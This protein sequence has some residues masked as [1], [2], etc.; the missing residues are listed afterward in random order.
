MLSKPTVAVV[1]IKAIVVVIVLLHSHLFGVKKKGG[2]CGVSCKNVI[3][4]TVKKKKKSILLNPTLS[5]HLFK[6][7]YEKIGGGHKALLL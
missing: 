1:W 3:D 6:I 5:T 4:E 2:G 7:L